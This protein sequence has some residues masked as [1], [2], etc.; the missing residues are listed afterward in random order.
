MSLEDLIKALRICAGAPGYE[1][2]I[3]LDCPHF[4]DCQKE[5]GCSGLLMAAADAL[6]SLN[7]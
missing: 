6:E 2:F 4:Q 7:K 3:C 5:P 1:E